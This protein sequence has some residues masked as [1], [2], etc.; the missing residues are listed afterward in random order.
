MT[1][2]TY[3][4]LGWDTQEPGYV[5][6]LW[7]YN[8][9]LPF[10]K[11]QE[12]YDD[13]D[14]IYLKRDCDG[15]FGDCTSECSRTFYQTQT[16]FGNGAD[17]PIAPECVG[18]DGLCVTYEWVEV[19]DYDPLECQSDCGMN[20]RID[21]RLVECRGTDGSVIEE[22]CDSDTK[23]EWQRTCAATAKMRL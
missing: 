6:H 11:I 10:D 13:Y 9:E 8:Y 18:G 15:T 12:H 7:V 5:S 23:P 3:Y 17:C 1:G 4:R 20:E 14:E 21:V 2:T 19:E 16:K 22:K